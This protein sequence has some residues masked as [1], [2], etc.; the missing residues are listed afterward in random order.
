MQLP[1]AA[2]AADS[3]KE[4]MRQLVAD[5][6]RQAE[7]Y[8]AEGSEGAQSPISKSNLEKLRPALNRQRKTLL[9]AKPLLGLLGSSGSTPQVSNEIVG[10]LPNLK[11]LPESPK[12]MVRFRKK[13]ARLA[14]GTGKLSLTILHIGKREES[15]DGSKVLFDHSLRAVL[16]EQYGDSGLGMIVPVRR[17]G[18]GDA[19]SYV[20]SKAGRW[21]TGTYLHRHK[22]GFG[23]SAM[24]A[25]SRSSL[26]SMTVTS[27]SESFDW[28]G[29]TIATGPSQ[30]T[31]TLK[32]GDVK[33]EFDANAET[34]GSSFFKLA[35]KGHS[36]TLTPGGGAQTAILNWST[37]R[38]QPGIRH[39]HFDL[40]NNNAK[41]MRRLDAT[42]VANDLRTLAPDLIM[43]DHAMTGSV[44]EQVLE[45]L[46]AQMRASAPQADILYLGEDTSQITAH[47]RSCM[48]GA[49]NSITTKSII[50]DNARKDA[51][52]WLWTP[53][54]AD[55]CA[56]EDQ[57][58]QGLVAADAANLTPDYAQRRAVDLAKWLANSA[59]D[60]G[61]LAQIRTGH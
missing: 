7:L 12:P 60:R 22:V 51:S 59:P 14:A 52:A 9:T 19:S 16:Q 26:S 55:I 1:F 24:R 2:K 46:I 40:L 58:R 18:E 5:L 32:V 57:L 38:N 61:K 21:R 28:V 11:S 48:N 33:R 54:R 39:V 50:N 56:I 4:V 35:V 17:F 43:I 49:A 13:L 25:T 53:N 20:V 47:Q 44:E 10:S 31:F 37:G 42:L 8:S 36:A 15:S 23:L 3:S 34:P 30:G 6:Y 29:V 27:K 45:D 41:Q